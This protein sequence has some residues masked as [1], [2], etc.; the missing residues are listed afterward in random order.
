MLSSDGKKITVES[1]DGL[2]ILLLVEDN[3][4]MSNYIY[5][6]LKNEYQV[7]IAENGKQGLDLAL[8]IIPDLIISDIMMPVMDGYEFCRAIKINIATSHIPVMLLSAKSSTESRIAGLET[9]ADVYMSK[10]FN[11]LELQLQVRNIYNQ[12]QKTKDKYIS[13]DSLIPDETNSNSMEQKFLSKLSELMEDNYRD[14]EYS[15]ELL[16]T[17]IGLSRSQLHRKLI[18]LTNISASKFIRT[19][20][21]KIAM[22]KIKAKS[23]NISEIAY[24]VG[25]N[26]VSYFNKCFLEH[27]GKRPGDI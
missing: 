23:G 16:S 3:S 26:N 9:E 10:P 1:N 2:P 4:D 22:K 8:N 19:Y 25:F 17:D 14:P 5:S 18:A 21:L 24:D 13:S 15:V 7:H 27:F 20:R 6:I 11:P 12:H